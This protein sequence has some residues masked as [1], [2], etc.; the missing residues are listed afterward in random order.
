MTMSSLALLNADQRQAVEHRNGPLLVLAGAGSGKTRVLTYRIAN[1][2][3]THQVDPSE[4]LAVT[5]TNKAAGEMKQ[6]IQQ[7]FCQQRAMELKN[8]PFEELLHTEQRQMQKWVDRNIIAPLWVGTFHAVCGRLLRACIEKYQDWNGRKWS[9]NFNIADEGDTQNLIKQIILHELNLDESRYP[10]RNIRYTISRAKNMGQTPEQFLQQEGKNFKNLKIAEVYESYQTK[11]SQN[12]TLDFD[13]LIFI[14]TQLFDQQPDLLNYW[15]QRFKHVL[16]DEYQ[17]TNRTQYKLIQQLVTGGKPPQTVSWEDRSVFVV[18]DADQ[19]I[20]GFRC[21]DFRIILAFQKEIGNEQSLVKLE[22][23][24]RSTPEIIEVANHIIV[25]N[26]ERFDKQLRPTRSSGHKVHCYRAD[27]EEEEG[28]FI[29]QQILNLQQNEGKRWK[30]FAILYRTNSQSRAIE[31]QLRREQIPYNVIG[32]LKFYDRK[33][34]KDIIAYLKLIHN[35]DDGLSLR[36]AIAAPRRGIGAKTLDHLAV[37]AATEGVSLWTIMDN[38]ERLRLSLS[39]SSKPVEQFVEQVNNW[40]ILA[41][42]ANVLEVLDAVLDK[43]GYSLALQTENT[44]EADNRLEN[45]LEMR[46][47]AQAFLEKNEDMNLSAYLAVISLYSDLD[48]FDEKRNQV[49]LMTVHA[50]KGLEFPVVFITGLEQGLFPHLRS[51]DDPGDLEEERRLCYVAITR[52]QSRLFLS[53]AQERRLWGNTAPAVPSQFL[54]ELPPE[55]MSGTLPRKTQPAAR[56][57]EP[58]P[59]LVRVQAHELKV[60]DRVLHKTFGS[61][62]VTHLLA[63]STQLSVAVEFPGLGK[64][65]INPKQTPLFW[66]PS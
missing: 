10:P 38:P 9:N 57:Q 22:E 50:S 5:F 24:Y 31:D 32:G 65:I 15:H 23:N 29:A 27:D 40:R 19:S 6:R 11:L 51:L 34:I 43:S 61:G 33:E 28:R 59:N 53:Y 45:I 46:S 41:E 8:M 39:R 36:R 52:A 2:I 64:K 30:D 35:P 66:M 26:E 62:K 20:Y 7:L 37:I 63:G 18:G 56:S 44:P 21:A 13:D 4:I 58:A 47:S 3:E 12:N 54:S 48:S 25:R 55:H 14:P 1:L 42:T 16:V 17:D 49:S 60:G